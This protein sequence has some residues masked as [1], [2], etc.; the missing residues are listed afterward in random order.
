[1]QLIVSREAY[2]GLLQAA[3]LVPIVEPEVLIEGAHTARTFEE[4]QTVST[5]PVKQ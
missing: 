3:K 5:E 2:C 4:V 1:M